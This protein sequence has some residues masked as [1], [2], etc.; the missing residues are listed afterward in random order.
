MAEAGVR[1]GTGSTVA[2]PAGA[3]HWLLNG[4]SCE[5][6]SPSSVILELARAVLT[7]APGASTGAAPA[8]NP[9]RIWHVDRH[10]ADPTT[11]QVR[12]PA[13]D[14]SPTHAT[15][16]H[17]VR[18]VEFAA[19]QDL[20][21]TDPATTSLH[22]ALLGRGRSGLLLVG[23]SEAGKSTLATAL[24]RQ[25]L[26][27]CGDDV[28]LVAADTAY[29]AAAP[30]RVSL[31]HGSRDLLGESLWQR[32]A[33]TPSFLATG[34]G[35][36][37]HPHELEAAAIPAGLTPAGILFLAR[38]GVAIGPAELR[39]I[40]AA[41]ALLALVP[42]SNVIRSA[43]MGAALARL[44]PLLARTPAHDLGRGPLPA[45]VA[46]VERLL[47]AVPEPPPCAERNTR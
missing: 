36:L 11:W 12:G 1:A 40:P 30:R 20:L 21:T 39:P 10:P 14:H 16:A 23:P 3:I 38:R 34:E 32:L 13:A 2:A 6:R 46:A 37:F 33:A 27:F 24:W 45:M 5:L 7:H 31:R 42:Y 43:G 35:C 19:L 29:L 25:G 4:R 9:E 18:A 41:Q 47:P 28:A 22:A 15:A 8:R 17:A 44:Q 26:S